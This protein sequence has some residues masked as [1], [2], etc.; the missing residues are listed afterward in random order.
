MAKD[1]IPPITE[2]KKNDNQVA[3]VEV[4]QSNAK[5]NIPNPVPNAATAANTTVAAQGGSEAPKRPAIKAVKF[6]TSFCEVKITDPNILDDLNM[7][8]KYAAKLPF[9]KLEMNFNKNGARIVLGTED[10]KEIIRDVSSGVKKDEC[11][12]IDFFELE[13]ETN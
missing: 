9:K 4:P 3:N 1:K 5:P 6:K 10:R 7:E 11:K 13:R 8:G 12:K 2:V